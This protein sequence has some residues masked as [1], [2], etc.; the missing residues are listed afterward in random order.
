MPRKPAHAPIEAGECVCVCVWNE[1]VCVRLAPD[2]GV[3]DHS[4]KKY[5]IFTKLSSGM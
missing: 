1:S 5:D 3:G 2:G 4:L